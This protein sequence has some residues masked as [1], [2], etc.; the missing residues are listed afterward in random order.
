MT[1]FL[2]WVHDKPKTTLGARSSESCSRYE[3]SQ[4]YACLLIGL[5]GDESINQRI[6][7]LL[8]SVR[9]RSSR[10]VAEWHISLVESAIQ[11]VLVHLRLPAL[12]ST[13][14]HQAI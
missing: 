6:T 5:S 3:V 7:N 1:C 12:R 14:S 10:S 8:P 13:L 11:F 4:I 2:F 9:Q